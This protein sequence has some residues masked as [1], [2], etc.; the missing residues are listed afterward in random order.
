MPNGAAGWDL[1]MVNKVFPRGSQVSW[2]SLQGF[3]WWD[4]SIDLG[5][6]VPQH[7]DDL[8]KNLFNSTLFNLSFGLPNSCGENDGNGKT[9]ADW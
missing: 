2:R 7:H 3:D 1:S 6:E 5:V 4:F 8:F 9:T